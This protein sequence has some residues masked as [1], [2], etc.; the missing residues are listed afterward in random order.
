MDVFVETLQKILQNFSEQLYFR[1]MLRSFLNCYWHTQKLSTVCSFHWVKKRFWKEI[2]KY[3]VFRKTKFYKN[4]YFKRGLTW[5]HVKLKWA[6]FHEGS[7]EEKKIVLRWWQTKVTISFGK[8]LQTTYFHCYDKKLVKNYILNSF[9]KASSKIAFDLR[10]SISFH[11]SLQGYFSWKLE[12]IKLS[13]A[14]KQVSMEFSNFF[15]IQRTFFSLRTPFSVVSFA[16]FVLSSSGNCEINYA[17]PILEI[18]GM[19]AF[20]GVHLSKKGPFVGLHPQN[21]C[22]F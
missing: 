20:F 12:T 16:V 6:I 10:N 2:S 14:W 11:D 15:E 3:S 5:R 13:L 8:S 22:H 1:L 18:G 17:G 9:Q 4:K 7:Y 21:R 19:V